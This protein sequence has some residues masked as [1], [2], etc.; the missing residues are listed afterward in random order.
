MYIASIKFKRD[1]LSY[2]E[3]GLYIAEEENSDK[4]VILDSNY[5]VVDDVL[6]NY[7]VNLSS[8]DKRLEMWIPFQI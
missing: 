6:E 4:S 8:P 5:R 3:E 7:T 2:W 1:G